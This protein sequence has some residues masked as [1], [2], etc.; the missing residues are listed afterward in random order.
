MM[1]QGQPNGGGQPGAAGG[2]APM[3]PGRTA[4]TTSPAD[5]MRQADRPGIP[6]G[7]GGG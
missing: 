2:G 5:V 4:S 1:P 7:P 6:T 3:N